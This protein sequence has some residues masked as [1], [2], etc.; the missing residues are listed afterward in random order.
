MDDVSDDGIRL[1]NISW[2]IIERKFDVGCLIKYG[3][4]TKSFRV[5]SK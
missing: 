1:L 3:K 5:N 2:E 4:V